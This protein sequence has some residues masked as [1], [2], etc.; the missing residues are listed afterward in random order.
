MRTDRFTSGLSR[1]DLVIGKRVLDLGAGTGL[2]SM[3]AA[4]LQHEAG[5]GTTT[6]TDHN[7]AVLERLA[8]NVERSTAVLRVLS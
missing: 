8:E 2:V 5:A 6:A 3:L 4:Y 7:E 1:A